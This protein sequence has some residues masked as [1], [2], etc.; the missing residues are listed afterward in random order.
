MSS[1][2]RSAVHIVIGLA[3]VAASLITS[4]APAGA[5]EVIDSRF[6]TEETFV[7]QT[8]RDL[9][10]RGPDAGGLAF[11]SNEL[12]RGLAPEAFV[13][14]LLLSPE[15]GGTIAPVVRLYSSVFGR[16]PDE[17]GLRFWVGERRAG[18]SLERLTARFIAGA[19]FDDLAAAAT[20]EQLVAAVYG[21]SLGRTPDAGGLAFWTDGINDGTF[22]LERFIVEVSESPEHQALTNSSVLAFLVYLGLQQR[23]PEPGGFAFWTGRLDAGLPLSSFVANVLTLPEYRSRFAVAPTL[24]TTVVAEG[25]TIPW[26]VESLPDGSVLATTRSGGLIILEPGEAAQGITLDL[27]DFWANGETGLMGLAVDPDFESSQRIYTCQGHTSP[28]EIQVIA[29]NLDVP[30]R[31]ATR[32]ADPLVGGLP[33][34]TGRHGGCQL[35]FDRE[36]HLYI[37]TGD[38]AVGTHP[39]NLGSLAGKVLRVDPQTGGPAAGNPFVTATNQNQ[40]LIWTYGHRNVQG[41]ALRPGTNE[42][43]SLEHGPSVDDEVNRLTRPGGNAGWNPVP[44]YNESVPM[45]DTRLGPDVF[46]AAWSTGRPTLALSGGDWTDHPNWGAW[47]NALGVAALK[48]QT[49]RLLFFNAEGLYLGQRVIIDGEFGRLRAVH[50]AADGSLYITTSTGSDRI[51]R[52]TPTLAD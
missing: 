1:V 15:F 34:T 38:S 36:G 17:G 30:G 31:A 43:W 45:T 27:D 29:W 44:G 40:R 7:D 21:R 11:W 10:G 23:T 4:P 13:E 20:T 49:L 18:D 2:R 51:I 48:N 37:G 19:E 35:E 52:V 16:L 14:Q 42:M 41:L 24:S 12:R 8:Y 50:Q 46:E 25:L 28:R 47:D 32:V 6:P 33:I 9:L 39:Q 26:D 5:G 22:T 3:M